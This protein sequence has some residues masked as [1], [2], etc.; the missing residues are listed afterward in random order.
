VHMLQF[1]ILSYNLCEWKIST[2]GD[3]VYAVEGW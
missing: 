3:L 2:D 1:Y